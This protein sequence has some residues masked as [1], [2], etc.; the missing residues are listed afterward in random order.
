[1]VQ[2]KRFKTKDFLHGNLIKVSACSCPN[3]HNDFW[4]GHRNKL[5]LFQQFCQNAPRRSWCCVAASRSE[6][7]CANAAT[8]RYCANSNFNVP[9]TCFIALIT[10]VGMYALTSPA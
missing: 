8:S 5:L 2:P 4:C 1:M 3:G 9:A 6:P 7:N 10:F